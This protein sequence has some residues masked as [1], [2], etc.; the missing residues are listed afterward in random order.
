MAKVMEKS[1]YTSRLRGGTVSMVS[2]TKG[3]DPRV[4]RTRQLLQQALME[5]FQEKSFSSISIQDITERA[6]VNRATFYAHFPD[7]YAL[8]DSLIREQF[9]QIVG[10]KLP[11]SPNWGVASLRVLIRSAFEFLGEFHHDCKP[12]DTQF[13]PLIERAVQQEL[14]EIL[15][16]WLKQAPVL[17]AG[18]RVPAKTIASV[19]SW[20]IFGTAVQ[21]GSNERTPS[22][23]EMTNQVLLVL[24][25]GVGHLAPGLLPD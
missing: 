13:D 12:S 4:K 15:L 24:T 14:A 9:Q 8:L 7:K 22:A 20:A 18:R 1:G 3:V 6:T 11:A 23:E 25:E 16:G 21:W 19:M 2:S 10:S 5:L 17:K